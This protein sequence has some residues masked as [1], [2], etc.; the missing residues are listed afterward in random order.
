MILCVILY[1]GS[2]MELDGFMMAH[3]YLEIYT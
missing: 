1:D 3:D 2:M